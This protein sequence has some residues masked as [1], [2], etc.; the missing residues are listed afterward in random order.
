MLVDKIHLFSSEDSKVNSNKR[1][2]PFTTEND[3]KSTQINKK[4]LA[5][6]VQ[7]N[8]LKMTTP[9][10][11]KKGADYNPA[12]KNYHPIN[13]AFWGFSEKVPYL[14][15]CR[16]F[17]LIENESSRLKIIDIL[18]NF[19][20]SVIVLSKNELISCIYLCLN[21][22]A[23]AYEG[24]ELGIAETYLMKAVA[25][26]TGRELSKIKHDVQKEGDLGIVAEKSRTNQKMMFQPSALTID[27]VFSKLKSIASL[28]GQSSMNKKVDMIQMM[29]VACRHSEAR[30]L[31]RSLAGKLRIGL[32]EQ[33]VLQA[34]AQACA[35]TSPNVQKYSNEN[36]NQLSN[37]NEVTAKS[38][39]E[40]L[41]LL[42]KETYCRCPNYDKL[43]PII[44]SDG[45]HALEEKCKMTPGVPLKPMLAMPTKGV[46]E[47]FER[48][49]GHDFTCEWK[50]DGERA[51]IHIDDSGKVFIYSRNSEN[52][53]SKYPDI[54]SRINKVKHSV[55]KSCILDCEVVAWDKKTQNILPFQVLT[56][57]KR[58]D[59]IEA[60]I[61]I[62]VCVYM[63]DILYL[64]GKSLIKEPFLERRR[65]L[66][67][68]F[69]EVEG[70]WKFAT[71]LDSNDI[72]VVQLF[73][74]EAVKGNC[75]GLMVK[76]LKNQATY[77]IAKRSKNWLKLKKDYLSNIGDSLDLVVIGGY[78]GKGKRT[79][80]YGGFLLACYDNEN[81]EFQTVCKIGT[82]FSDEDL[83][84]HSNLLKQHII[85][86]PKH[87]F[88]FDMNHKPDDWFE[89]VQVWEIKCADLSISPVYKAALGIVDSEKGISLRFP[90][91]IR[92]REDKSIEDST[93]AQQIADM[94][95][96][97][98]QIKNQEQSMK[99][100]EED[101]Y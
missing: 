12:K 5:P 59:V 36:L 70:E 11:G 43:I 60:D 61:Q 53:T 35:M 26:S 71:K 54:I 91:Y 17:E 62:E 55:V 29:F 52:N 34:L 57:R 3:K 83:I 72:E 64:N 20:R 38:K 96:N 68:N 13:D 33:S 40:E 42:I 78:I 2:N 98:D 24:V 6:N 4:L 76:T 92:V 58:K 10:E 25:Q 97:Q 80:T 47:I 18:S 90:R 7:N 66:Y 94:Y 95:Y 81:E 15:I 46:F 75:E 22:L 45:V 50:Y 41:S 9:G 51:Q 21:Q 23:P 14:A 8:E 82:G 88:R 56:T 73:L 27:G 44:L 69:I 85:N 32:A 74:D 1:K 16:T 30:F 99:I 89:P 49:E 37:L 86:E 67:E 79:G 63:F 65:L 39:I 28:S 93:T 101:F 77:E 19:F 100:I 48:F 31:I 84:N 87:Y